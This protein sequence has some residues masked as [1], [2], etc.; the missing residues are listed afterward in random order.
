VTTIPET[1]VDSPLSMEDV[2]ASDAYLDLRTPK[3]RVGDPA[4]LF[5]LP[6]DTGELVRLTDF[7]GRS[8]V[9]L[10]FGSYT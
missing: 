3:L 7:V 1:P 10:V 6:R 5:E 4:F 8:P 9:A 2:L